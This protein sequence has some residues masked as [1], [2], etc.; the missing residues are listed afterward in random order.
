MASPITKFVALATLLVLVS[1]A[2]AAIYRTTITE[3][4][5]NEESQSQQQRCQQEVQRKP[6]DSCRTYLQYG[7]GGRLL[8]VG[9]ARNQGQVPQECC[10]QMRNVREE[11]RC[12]ALRQMV[13][14]QQ[15]QPGQG[16]FQGEEQE[17]I[18]QR[19]EN[20]PDQCKLRPQSCQIGG[21]RN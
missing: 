21:R 9:T 7:Q 14:E 5:I 18:Q 11:C 12:E 2:H 16:E 4:V 1:M 19:A 6:L 15:Q 3:T 17:E 13:R 8:M 10:Q 20:I